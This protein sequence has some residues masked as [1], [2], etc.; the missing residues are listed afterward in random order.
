MTIIVCKIIIT[1]H[2]HAHL[3]LDLVKVNAS[4]ST[5]TM[6]LGSDTS[7][8]KSCSDTAFYR[9]HTITTIVDRAYTTTTIVSLSL[10]VCV[11]VSDAHIDQSSLHLD[12]TR[13]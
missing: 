10:C 7:S 4:M 8:C 1:I 12:S 9:I 13:H 5:I 3:F 11:C 2:H 6:Q